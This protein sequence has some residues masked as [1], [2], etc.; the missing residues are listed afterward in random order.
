MTAATLLAQPRTSAHGLNR[1]TRTSLFQDPKAYQRWSQSS[2]LIGGAGMLGT[3]LASEAVRAG[4]RVKVADLG[5]ITDTVKIGAAHGRCGRS[6]A[7]ALAGACDAINPGRAEALH[8]DLRHVGIGVFAESVLIIDA[9]DDP[10]LAGYLTEISNGLQIPLIRVAVDGSGQFNCGRVLISHG[11]GG[12]A[13]QM[14]AWQVQHL[15]KLLPRTPCPGAPDM[16][17]PTIATNATSTAVAGLAL[18]SAMRLLGGD[19]EA[20]NREIILDLDNM[21]IFE[22]RLVRSEQCVSRHRSW[23]WERVEA[24]ADGCTLQNAFALLTERLGVAVEV[25]A[26]NHPFWTAATCS[27]CGDTERAVGTWW[28]S[29]PA[30]RRCGSAAKWQ[31]GSDRATLGMPDAEQLGVLDCTL[32]EL[33]LPAQGAMLIGRAHRAPAVR[34]V[35]R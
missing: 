29:P 16:P 21:T 31:L 27:N 35:L 13:C 34:I 8:A 28:A 5:Q 7:F 23:T 30:C 11:G 3:P 25:E 22:Q 24:R 4:T 33:G 10:S 1:L 15:L 14:C 20:F 2:L 26:F 12:Y 9:T 32:A 19:P 6:K 17:P 18:H